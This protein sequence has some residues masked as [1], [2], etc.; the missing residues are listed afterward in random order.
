M[1]LQQAQGASVQSWRRKKTHIPFHAPWPGSKQHPRIMDQFSADGT[2]PQ[3]CWRR[4][5]RQQ[6]HRKPDGPSRKV[7]EDDS[8][9][10][11][12]Q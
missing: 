5:Q 2:P 12:P 8:L 10:H 4:R 7:R 11:A 1:P 3:S 6:E 9:R